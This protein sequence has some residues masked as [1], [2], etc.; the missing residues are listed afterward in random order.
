M[1]K[2]LI[3]CVIVD[4][5]PLARTIIRECLQEHTDIHIQAEYGNPIEA[6]LHLNKAKTDLL[7]LDIQMPELNGF[8]LLENLKNPPL[9]IFCTA[10][11]EYAI[12]A[13]EANAIDYLLKP[14]DQERFN[15]AI[16]KAKKYLKG[17]Q[18]NPNLE[19]LLRYIKNEK[20]E[21]PKLLVK[22]GD[23][24][25]VLTSMD[26]L[27]AEAQEDYCLLHCINNNYLVSRS[28]QELEQRFSTFTFKR[29]HRSALVNFE[30]V[31]EIHPWSSGRYLLK[32]KNGDEIESSKSGARLIKNMLL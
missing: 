1:N 10:Y 7:F 28:L 20:T 26:I 21:H 23:Q 12:K 5:E 15:I 13:F 4:D 30:M 3:N 14:F 25:I 16:A 24:L 11:D 17:E 22:D 27:W 32:M 31:K 2:D 8:E 29:V 18:E 6:N 9:I 19:Q